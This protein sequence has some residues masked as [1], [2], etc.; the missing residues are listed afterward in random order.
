MIVLITIIAAALIAYVIHLVEVYKEE[1]RAI[2]AL[3]HNQR[4]MS[5]QPDE[6][7]SLPIVSIEDIKKSVEAWCITGDDDPVF[8]LGDVFL[9]LGYRE[10][11]YTFEQYLHKVNN[12]T[13]HELARA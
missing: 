10:R 3:D 11:G 2:D 12:G 6:P 13:W 8:K 9:S 7:I 5:V 4:L 1:Q